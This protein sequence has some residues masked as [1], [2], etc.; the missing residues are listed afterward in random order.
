MSSG[1]PKGKILLIDDSETVLRF[2]HAK[3]EEAG[4]DVITTTQTVGAGRMLRGVDLVVVD[5]HMPGLDG[6]AVAQSL[7]AAAR[8]V[9]AKPSFY[10]YTSDPQ[11]LG[12]AQRLGFDGELTDKA[13][14]DALPRQVD[15]ALRLARLRSLRG[16]RKP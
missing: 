8:S 7:R 16:D 12:Q 5:Y 11:L 2:A 10:L 9:G 3:L 6:M 1:Q 13:D 15:A 14:Y 4:Y